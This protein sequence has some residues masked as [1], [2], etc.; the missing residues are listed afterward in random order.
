ML[1][2]A[3]ESIMK[4]CYT[5]NVVYLHNFSYF[6]AVFLIKILSSFNAK[7]SPIIRDNCKLDNYN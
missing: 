1:L 7:I 6:D 4:P 3:M 5:K 2:A